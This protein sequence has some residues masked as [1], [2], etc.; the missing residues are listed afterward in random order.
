M[1]L[2]RLLGMQIEGARRA[3]HAN[4]AA[5]RVRNIHRRIAHC[6][7][8]DLHEFWIHGA[9]G[10]ANRSRNNLV[11]CAVNTMCKNMIVPRMSVFTQ[12][13]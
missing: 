11:K 13:L 6:L 3:K 1:N 7:A 12:R 4:D 5:L 10:S 8:R 2:Q 9:S